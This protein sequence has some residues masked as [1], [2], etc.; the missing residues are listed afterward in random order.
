MLLVVAS[1]DL[2]MSGDLKQAIDYLANSRH[3]Y[4]VFYRHPPDVVKPHRPEFQD[5]E[6]PDGK[7]VNATHEDFELTDDHVQA[8]VDAYVRTVFA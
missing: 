1:K 3:K 8:I 5:L 2:T 7:E 4:R 6:T